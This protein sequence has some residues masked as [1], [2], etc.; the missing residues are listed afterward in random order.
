MK[1]WFSLVMLVAENT[2]AFIAIE[3]KEAGSIEH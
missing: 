1:L 2:T 3:T